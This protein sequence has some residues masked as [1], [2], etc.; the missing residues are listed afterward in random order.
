M[1]MTQMEADDH[2]ALWRL[3]ADLQG[4]TTAE[5]L[6]LE[7]RLATIHEAITRAVGGQPEHA[8]DFVRDV[9]IGRLE[10]PY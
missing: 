5:S 8:R 10:P 3:L 4:V 2:E 9:L 1:D 7:G 6:T